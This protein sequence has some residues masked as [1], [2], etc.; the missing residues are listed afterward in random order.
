MTPIYHITHMNNLPGIIA[1][2]GLRCDG[3][4]A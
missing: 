2:G 1:A 3:L 4:R